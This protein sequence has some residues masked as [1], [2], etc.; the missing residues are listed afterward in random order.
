MGGL[1]DDFVAF[2][3]RWNTPDA[4]E[5]EPAQF[6]RE[7]GGTRATHVARM[8]AEDGGLFVLVENR[9]R[10]PLTVA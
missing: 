3:Q 9:E 5:R 10:D 2:F 4:I 8:D 7:C 6:L 1:K